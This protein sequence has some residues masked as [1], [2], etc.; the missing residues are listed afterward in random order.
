MLHYD[1]VNYI[2]GAHLSFLNSCVM[3]CGIATGAM[4]FLASVIIAHIAILRELAL[5]KRGGV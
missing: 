3:L 5:G 1:A 2:I 4:Q